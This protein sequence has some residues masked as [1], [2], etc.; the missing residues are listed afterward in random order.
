MRRKLYEQHRRMKTLSLTQPWATLIMIGLKNFE[1][2]S[3]DTKHRGPLQIHASA[4]IDR[5]GRKLWDTDP[6]IK[7]MRE[8]DML[9][10]FDALPRGAILGEVILHGTMPTEAVKEKDREPYGDFSAGRFAWLLLVTK[11][12]KTPIPCKGQLGLWEFP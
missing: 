11:R 8:H 2:R 3:W 1:T 7:L 10:E 6:V 9:G 4:T 5:A 12:F